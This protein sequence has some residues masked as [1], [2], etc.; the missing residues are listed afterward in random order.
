MLP[1]GGTVS[2]IPHTKGRWEIKLSM[3]QYTP[4]SRS[5]S[6]P[7]HQVLRLKIIDRHFPLKPFQSRYF[8]SFLV[9]G[10]HTF[11]PPLLWQN[12]TYRD[13]TLVTFID[14]CSAV[15]SRCAPASRHCE[16]HRWWILLAPR[17]FCA[18]AQVCI[19]QR[20][21]MALNTPM[22]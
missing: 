18:A 11:A 10:G 3:L 22:N 4:W 13:L 2:N 14:R 5:R 19:A 20:L 6:S 1:Q 15:T 21:F 12:P 17:L 8:V 9:Q 16:R 7:P